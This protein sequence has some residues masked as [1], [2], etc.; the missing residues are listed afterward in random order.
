VIP[1]QETAVPSAEFE[2]D[3]SPRDTHL[4]TITSLGRLGRQEVI[5]YGQRAL[6]ET[7]MGRYEALIDE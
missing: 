4:L 2:T 1:L 7:A 3:P 5:G 6:V